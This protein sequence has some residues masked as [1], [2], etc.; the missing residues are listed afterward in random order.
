MGLTITRERERITCEA[1]A[2]EFARR[3]VPG[4]YWSFACDATGKPAPDVSAASLENWQRCLDGDEDV[5]DLGIQH[6]TWSYMQP[7]E[8]RCVCGATVELYGDDRGEGI[9]CDCGRVYNAL[10]QEL[11]PR[12]QWEPDTFECDGTL[13]W[14]E[15]RAVYPHEYED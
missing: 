8:G 13:D 9:D 14:N 4:G 7:A 12:A 2:H 15:R 11:A 1:W 5:E 10:G 3:D 6:R